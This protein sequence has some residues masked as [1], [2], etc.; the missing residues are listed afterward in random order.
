VLFSRQIFWPVPNVESK[1]V[2]F[3]RRATPGDEALRL[4]TFAIIDLAFAQRRKMLRSALSSRYG[5][6]APA[7][8]V[9]SGVGIDPT[10]RGEALDISAF[11]AIAEHEIK[12]KEIGS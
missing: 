8:L 5:G 2:S 12:L 7:E 6:S 1:L 4:R 9:L 10:L 11:V 3:T